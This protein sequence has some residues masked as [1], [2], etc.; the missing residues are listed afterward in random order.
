[1]TNYTTL[2]KL[3][4]L[5]RLPLEGHIDL[6]Y[7]CN[8][9]CLHCWLWK[10]ADAPEQKDELTLNEIK[11]IVDQ[12][13]AMGTQSWGISG[14]EPMLRPDFPEI[15]DYITQKSISYSLNTN[16]TLIT[17]AIAQQ[18]KRKGNKMIALY[19]ATAETY[20]K[21]TRHPGGF[22]M[23]MRGFRYM[24]E[25]GAGF[26]V[27]LI[28]MKSN[29]HEWEQM[30][31]LAKSLSKDWRVGA[32]WLY[33]NAYGDQKRN[34]EIANQRLDAKT[35][36]ELDPPNS[37]MSTEQYIDS[38]GNCVGCDD[39]LFANCIAGHNEF[40]IDPFGGMTFCSFI[41]DPAMFYD[42]PRGT[43]QEAWDNFIPSLADKVI[44]GREYSENCGSCES[45][46]NCRWCGVY[47]YLE[48][49]RYSAPVE[50]LCAAAQESRAY[51]A[52]YEKDHCRYFQIAGITV[53]VESD[54]NFNEI[55]FKREFSSI[56]G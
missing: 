1:M 26:T 14:G 5:P 37:V 4:K 50:Y 41:K 48:H 17:P 56:Y 10:P 18:L 43:F 34:A 33:F 45:R 38:D 16:G 40:Q 49:G 12:A 47:G 36:I 25:A 24:Q 32:S 44:G 15:F 9:N 2:K 20:D 13:R 22:E 52:E 3:E 8:N 27:Q 35:V 53:K 7:R 30:Q 29:W 39:H 28:P 51:Q 6:T 23:A 46:K 21:V 42:L 55:K 19:G 31:E 11:N 54:L